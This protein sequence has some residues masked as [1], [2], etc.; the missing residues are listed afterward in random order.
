MI[1]QARLLLDPLVSSYNR[2]LDGGA[3]VTCALFQMMAALA[4]KLDRTS[5]L[6]YHSKI[7][8]TCLM[9]LDLRHDRPQAFHSMAEV[10]TSV[11]NTLVALILKLSESS[12]KPLFVSLLEWA[13]SNLTHTDTGTLYNVNRNIAFYKLVNQLTE[14]LRY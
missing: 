11:V 2:A 14:K 7:F 13:Q 12:F 10:E 5:V 1:L 8:N 3:E 4:A 6:S 9:A